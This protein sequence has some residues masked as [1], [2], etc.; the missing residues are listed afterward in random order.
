MTQ[1]HQTEDKHYLTVCATK[2]RVHGNYLSHLQQGDPLNTM[3]NGKYIP[4]CMEQI[5]Q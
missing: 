1:E 5:S 4:T 2:N 3:E